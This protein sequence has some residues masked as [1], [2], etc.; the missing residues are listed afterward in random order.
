M[1]VRHLTGFTLIEMLIA[2]ILVAVIAAIA[3]PSYQTQIRKSRRSDAIESVI[4]AHLAEESFRA[5]NA[6]YAAS[7]TALGFASSPVTSM[8]G[9]YSIAL[10]GASATG[11]VLTATAV[12]GTSQAADAGCTSII[13][14]VAA[15]S[16]A[17]TPSACWNR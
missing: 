1:K 15:G 12:S 4:R 10:S 8:D 3:L 17:Q 2:V 7:L 9:Y 14:T 5:S 13:L 6:T 11:Y 16:I